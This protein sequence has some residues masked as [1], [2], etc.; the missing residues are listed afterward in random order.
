MKRKVADYFSDVFLVD[1]QISAR[2]GQSFWS[3]GPS[4]SAQ[5]TAEDFPSLKPIPGIR[6]EDYASVLQA[7]IELTQILHNAHAILYSST[8]RTLT[9]VYDGDYA[10]YLDDFLRSTNSWHAKWNVV[11][12]SHKIKS[13]LLLTYEYI[14]LYINAF[15]FQAVLTRTAAP[16]PSL[17][18]RQRTCK[19]PLA[20]LFSGG[21]MS[22]PDGRYVFDAISAAKN[23]LG[24]VNSLDPQ[25]VICYLP[26]RYYL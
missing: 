17:P 25:R 4:L 26:S 21:V 6:D 15:S 5:F 1:R 18:K 19:R 2:L 14:C 16:R 23:L 24:L 12:A 10:R 22:S 20:E 11:Q 3:R 13:T 7:N 9:M 8:E